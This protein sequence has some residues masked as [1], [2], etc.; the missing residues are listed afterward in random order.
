MKWLLIAIRILATTALL[1]GYNFLIGRLAPLTG[2]PH[3]TVVATVNFLLFLLISNLVLI[4]LGAIYR[5]RKKMTAD[6]YDNV[7]LGLNNIYYLLIAGAII[8]TI[9]GF[10][11]IDYVTL[12]TSLSIVAA[13]IAII[14]R[15]FISEII[16][17]IIISFS[18]ELDIGDYV[19][20]GEHKGRIS[21]LTIT[22]IALL[23]DDDVIIFIPNTR[24]FSSDIVN[25]T[26]KEIRK[27][28]IEFEAGLQAIRS[29]EA[30]EADL[31]NT[32][33]YYRSYIEERSYNLRIVEIRKDSVAL[34]FQYVL[35]EIDPELEREIRRKTARRIIDYMLGIEDGSAG[36][37]S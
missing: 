13:A 11:G 1:L 28:S 12:F 24:V 10:M 19:R 17:G 5:Q 8:L 15:E 34:K 14:S 33:R 3:H 22:R 6:E 9:L 31:I 37:V 29:I 27:V 2:I 23:N 35:H 21:D 26:K 32:L 25:F 16:S 4:T 36:R 7:I 18:K 30:L 20:I